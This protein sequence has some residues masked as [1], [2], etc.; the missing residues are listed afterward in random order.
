MT[1]PSRGVRYLSMIA[2]AVGL[3]AATDRAA[4]QPSVKLQIGGGQP[5]VTQAVGGYCSARLK[6]CF[7]AQ[8]MRLN[9]FRFIGARITSLAPDS[10][11]HALGL[12]VG[13]VITRLDGV[14][15]KTGMIYDPISQTRRLPQMERHYGQTRVRYIRTGTKVVREEI[16]NLGPRWPQ[17][18]PDGFGGDGLA[19]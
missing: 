1:A 5:Q 16:T 8:R 11:L 12:Q 9:G 13:D 6:G 18:D 3:A 10:P 14:P 15:I 7:L 2:V 19:P 17:F 4:A